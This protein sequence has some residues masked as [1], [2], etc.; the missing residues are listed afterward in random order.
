M[1]STLR[2]LRLICGRNNRPS[3]STIEY[4]VATFESTGAVQNVS[5]SGRQK[6]AR[7]VEKIAAAE[8][9]VEDVCDVVMANFANDLG[10]H[11]YKIK[12]TQELKPLYYQKC[13][14]FVNWAE[15]QLETDSD[16]YRKIIFSNEDNFWLNGFVNKQNMRYW[17]DSNPHIRHESSL[18]PEKIT[19]RCG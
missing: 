3:R 13:R 12:F 11:P 9:S 4:L 19:L 16:F 7:S 18:H 6:S 5:V 8:V 14:M 10:L 2:T 1:A 15:Q 17:S